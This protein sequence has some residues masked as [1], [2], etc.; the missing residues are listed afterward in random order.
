MKI[1]LKGLFSFLGVVYIAV[2]IFTTA[3]LLNR[4]DYSVTVFGNSSLFIVNEDE[5]EPNYSANTLLVVNK[6]NSDNINVGDKIFYY[7]TYSNEKVIK[8]NE[9]TKKEKVTDTETTFITKE[10]KVLSGQYVL[11]TEESTTNYVLLG[12]ILNVLQSKW[13]FLFFILF[14]LFLAFVY[15]IYA[16]IKE[17]KNS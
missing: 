16:I 3:F 15:E 9:V 14:P 2:A 1:I 11:G 13:G 6:E 8:Y 10:N 7:D 17:V 4:N 12:S 5:L